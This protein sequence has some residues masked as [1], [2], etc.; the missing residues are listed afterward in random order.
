MNV[1]NVNSAVC[2]WT[3][4]ENGKGDVYIPSCLG[5]SSNGVNVWKVARKKNISILD[6]FKKCPYCGNRV[7]IKPKKNDTGKASR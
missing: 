3:E 5:K 4:K 2:T 1:N 7:I 6:I